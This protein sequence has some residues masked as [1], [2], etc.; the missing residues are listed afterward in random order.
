MSCL[1]RH[2]KA[3][4]SLLALGAD[5]SMMFKSEMKDAGSE[6]RTSLMLNCHLNTIQLLLAVG[7][8]S[9]LG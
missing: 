4:Q 5:N 6:G 1:N 2:L 7:A 3:I 9:S 8:V